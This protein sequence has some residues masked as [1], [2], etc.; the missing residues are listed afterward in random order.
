M[1]SGPTRPL[2]ITGPRELEAALKT[3]GEH[4]RRVLELRHGLAGER[5]HSL[6]EI[7]RV[8]GFSRERARQLETRALRKLDPHAGARAGEPLRPREGPAPLPKGFL[9]PWTLLLLRESPAHGYELRERLGKAGLPEPDYRFLRG[10]EDEGLLRSSWARASGAGPARRTY[11]LTSK[12]TKQL[13]K[14]AEMLGKIDASLRVFFSHYDEVAAQINR[15]RARRRR[16]AP[17]SAGGG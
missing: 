3:L 13:R 1:A 12:G 14:E 15:D 8:L 6:V 10:L 5:Q 9:R 11:R 16:S 4:E 7:G 2:P 17:S